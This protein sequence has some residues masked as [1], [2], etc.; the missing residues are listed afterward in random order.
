MKARSNTPE[1]SE[2]ALQQQ[3][4]D[5]CQMRGLS[6]Y[7]THDSRRSPPGFP[8]LVIAGPGGLLFA[9][10]KTARG[11]VT[12]AQTTWLTILRTAGAETH[13]W[14][15]GD[16]PAISTRLAGLAKGSPR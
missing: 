15:P 1:I 16:L 3:V 11:R 2:R 9:E 5:L 10:L 8:D 14:R 12:T 4:L 6:A 13:L 7:H